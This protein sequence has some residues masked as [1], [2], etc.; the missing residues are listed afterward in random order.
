MTLLTAGFVLGLA[1]SVHCVFMCGPLVLAAAGPGRRRA[2]IVSLFAHHGGRLL[3]Y[4]ALGIA[5]AVLGR[6]FSAAG[7]GR[8]LSI[9]CGLALVALALG[10]PSRLL[11]GVVSGAW[12]RTL[13][14]ATAVISQ[15]GTTRP[16]SIR[17]LTG[18][19]NG[20][21]PCGLTYAAAAAAATLG[22]VAAAAVFMAGFGAGTLPALLA[23][24]LSAASL[25]SGLR[26]HLQRVAPVA[27]A[28]TGLLL[29]ARG[30]AAVDTGHQ[31]H[32]SHAPTV[33]STR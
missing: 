16:L 26:S 23:V 18:V 7:L 31:A 1:G 13:M 28:L 14:R 15:L 5:A 11:P 22:S 21:I 20:L 17:F 4:Q 6:A 30:V 9:V 32:A 2:A 24:S 10:R 25:P 33:S 29:V 27:L 12:M 19:V 8:A 3:V